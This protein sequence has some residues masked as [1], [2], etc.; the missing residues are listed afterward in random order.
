[1]TLFKVRLGPVAPG[2]ATPGP[3]GGEGF[4]HQ[5][6][7]ELPCVDG[8]YAVIGSWVIAGTPR[9]I[10]IREDDTPITRDSSR[11]VPH[12]FDPRPT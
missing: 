1:M 9:G 2:M 7:A 10:G 6:Y 11:F 4:V 8:R 3:Y 5:A 12:F